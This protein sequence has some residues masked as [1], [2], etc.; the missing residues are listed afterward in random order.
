M[1]FYSFALS[2]PELSLFSWDGLSFSIVVVI[3]SYKQPRNYQ[4]YFFP[5]KLSTKVTHPKRS[6]KVTEFHCYKIMKSIIGILL[7]S[8]DARIKI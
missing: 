5:L 4:I 6:A 2:V 7:V 8:M 3:Q 1:I